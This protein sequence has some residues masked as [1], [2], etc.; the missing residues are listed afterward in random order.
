MSKQTFPID[1]GHAVEVTLLNGKSSN[2]QLVH[3]PSMSFP[4]WTL[5][6]I[7]YVGNNTYELTPIFMYVHAFQS[8]VKLNWIERK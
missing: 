4:Y 2:A 3:F 5:Q 8:I 6:R 7:V 1:I